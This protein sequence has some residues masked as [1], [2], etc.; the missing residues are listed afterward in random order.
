MIQLMKFLLLAC[1]LLPAAA[2]SQT[3][4][5]AN[6]DFE[7]AKAYV[8]HIS[9]IHILQEGA[10]KENEQAASTRGSMIRNVEQG[11][12]MILALKTSI[13]VF[14]SLRPSKEA[15]KIVG[16][17]VGTNQSK[18]ELQE[19]LVEIMTTL[20]SAKNS[21]VDYGALSAQVAKIVA[22]LDSCDH[23]IFDLSN[24]IFLLLIDKHTDLSGKLTRLAITRDQRRELTT[25]INSTFGAN[26]DK[27][28]PN[29]IESAAILMKINLAKGFKSSDD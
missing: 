9:E 18:A 14:K 4:R 20:L 19:K 10:R 29:W 15:K 13:S 12:R 26:L 24:M 8:T 3:E 23:T 1:F 25:L 22:L 16:H 2:I 6:S 17:L 28:E 21:N 5:A 7:I 27:K 11:T